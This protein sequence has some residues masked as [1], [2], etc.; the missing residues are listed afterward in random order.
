MD[1]NDLHSV[2]RAADTFSR[3]ENR[4]DVLWNNAGPGAKT[5]PAG[6][7]TA[8][9]LEPMMGTHCV[10]TLFFTVRLLPLLRAAAADAQAVPGATRVA[11][12]TSYLA[13]GQAPRHGIGLATLREGT[14]DRV[15]NYAMAKAGVWMLA[16]ELAARADADAVLSVVL[17]PGN[18]RAGSYAGNSAAAMLLL[19]P[20][21]HETKTAAYTG[22]FAGLAPDVARAGTGS[23]YVVPWGRVRPDAECP[24]PDILLAMKS[25]EEGGLGYGKELWEWCEEQ[26]KDL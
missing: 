15:R 3:L 10:A 24:R 25:D 7:T 21:L 17:N 12:T 8:Q 22:L 13:E 19:K 4:L 16:H 14:K 23:C 5:V 20:L 9:G 26:W 1:L 2:A 6:A 11:W 18:V